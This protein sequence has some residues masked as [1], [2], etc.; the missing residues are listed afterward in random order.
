MG[1][2]SETKLDVQMAIGLRREGATICFAEVR[3]RLGI[4]VEAAQDL[5]SASLSSYRRTTDA[6]G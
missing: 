1:L 3:N 5:R 4:T 2:L 6:A